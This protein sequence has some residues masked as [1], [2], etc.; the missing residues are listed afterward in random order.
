MFP[1]VN[2]S[3][4]Q[5]RFTRRHYYEMADRGFFQGKRVELIAGEIVRKQPMTPLHAARRNPA[6]CAGNSTRGTYHTLHTFDS[7]SAVSTLAMQE[8]QISIADLLP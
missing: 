2:G 8:V 5:F 4:P 6:I 1:F 3:P 7:T